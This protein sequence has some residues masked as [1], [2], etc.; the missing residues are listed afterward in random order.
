MDAFHLCHLRHSLKCV[1]PLPLTGALRR[2]SLSD[3]PCK[4]RPSF[5]LSFARSVSD[6]FAAAG[7]A[8]PLRN[9]YTD[10]LERLSALNN[11]VH[12]VTVDIA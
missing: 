10:M 6:G 7:S 9:S 8:Y 3:Y 4:G 2:P 1:Y 12:A 5:I 11:L